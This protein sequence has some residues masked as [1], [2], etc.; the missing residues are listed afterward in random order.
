MATTSGQANIRGIDVDKLA[1]GFAEE[2]NVFKNFLTIS[3]TGAREMRWYQKTAGFLD[4]TDTTGITASQIYNV[5]PGA[6]PEVVEASWS[7]MTSYVKKYFVESPWLTFEDIA[8][9]DIDVLATNVR[10]LTRAVARQVDYR[11]F[12]VL[13]GSCLL[14][15]SATAGWSVVASCNPILDL[16][17]GS[18]EIRKQSYDISNLVVLMHPNEYKGL[19]NYIITTKGS[20]IPAFS[21]SKVESGVL[22]QILGQRI[23]VSA[24]ATAGLVLQIVPQRAATWK[25]FTP[26][27]AQTKDEIGIG[28][29]IRVWEEGEV[30]FTDPNAVFLTKGCA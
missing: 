20:S 2:E 18:V 16:L 3:S 23:V 7:R 6:L 14:S 21:S 25:T 17:S 1:K 29:K 24:N 15:G 30:E 27:T 8:D 10:D 12:D 22:L 11:I 28:T 5:A 13:S 19:M 4:S 26:I 9:S